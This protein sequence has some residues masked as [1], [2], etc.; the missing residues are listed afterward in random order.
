[1]LAVGRGG[2][3]PTIVKILTVVDECLDTLDG[4]VDSAAFQRHRN[5]HHQILCRMDGHRNGGR[6][7]A[8]HKLV[9][10]TEPVAEPNEHGQRQKAHNHAHRQ[11]NVAANG[12]RVVPAKILRIDALQHS[13]IGCEFLHHFDPV[14][15]LDHRCGA[16]DRFCLGS[17]RMVYS[18]SMD[19]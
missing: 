2:G 6:Y 11:Q 4:V 3:G 16:H 9:L 10:R 15:W 5:V 8:Q 14:Q 19:F 17:C 12:V 18:I 1:M 13:H 7:F